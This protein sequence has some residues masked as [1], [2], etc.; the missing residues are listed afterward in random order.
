MI[1]GL[2][3]GP[4]LGVAVGLIGGIQ[5]LSLGGETAVTCLIATVL[6]GLFAGI[7]Y[8]LNK[9]KLP[10]IIPAMA[11]CA[12][13]EVLH[14]LMGMLTIQSFS[15]GIEIFLKTTPSM[16]IANALGLAICIIII[17]G[18][19]ELELILHPESKDTSSG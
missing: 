5:R 11:F 4:Y 8:Q 17:H 1:S 7:I 18:R 3:G 15:E 2:V 9:G 19:I 6:A 16:V 13:F 14:G 10:G 12:A